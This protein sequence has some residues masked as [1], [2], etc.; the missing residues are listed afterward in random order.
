LLNDER[1]SKF[2][3]GCAEELLGAASVKFSAELGGKMGGGSED[4]AY[5]SR[6]IPAVMVA[7][8][9]GERAAGF[10]YPLHH[11]KADF[12]EKVLPIGAALLAKNALTWTGEWSE[13][14]VGKKNST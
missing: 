1:A 11:P 5:F 14:T 3:H 9:A 6:E 7:L 10:I 13:K 12:D 4:F 2:V 8:C